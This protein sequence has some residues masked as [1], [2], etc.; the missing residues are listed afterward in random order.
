MAVKNWTPLERRKKTIDGFTVTSST[1]KSKSQGLLNFYVKEVEDDLEIHLFS[2]FQFRDVFQVHKAMCSY[3]CI[4]LISEKSA[5]SSQREL[6]IFSL[7]TGRY[8][9]EPR[10][11][12]VQNSTK[13]REPPRQIAQIG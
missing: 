10:S 11:V 3:T 1:I 8:I 7:I 12:S 6:Q 5:L 4:Y 13:V 2:S 9:G